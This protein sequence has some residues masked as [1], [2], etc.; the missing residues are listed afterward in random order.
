MERCADFV[1]ERGIDVDAMFTEKW[2]LSDA[3]EAYE[4]FDR[5]STGNGAFIP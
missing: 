2:K 3:A 1:L 5:Q 4:L